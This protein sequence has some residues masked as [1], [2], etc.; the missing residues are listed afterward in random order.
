MQEHSLNQAGTSYL[1]I[2]KGNPDGGLAD[3]ARLGRFL[4][5]P[6]PYAPRLSGIRCSIYLGKFS[7]SVPAI[8][9]ANPPANFRILSGQ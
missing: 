2:F 7:L 3:S 8:A 5:A 1:K 6:I 9:E 4:Q